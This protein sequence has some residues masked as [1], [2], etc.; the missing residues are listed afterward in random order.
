[1]LHGMSLATGDRSSAS[2]PAPRGRGR[3]R[4]PRS[5]QFF[6]QR[7][8]GLSRLVA[9]QMGPIAC[10]PTQPSRGGAGRVGRSSA[11]LWTAARPVTCAKR[12]TLQVR[13]AAHRPFAPAHSPDARSRSPSGDL[14]LILE[15]RDGLRGRPGPARS[16]FGF[17]QLA[18]FPTS[19][20]LVLSSS[21]ELKG[22]VFILQLVRPFRDMWPPWMIRDCGRRARDGAALRS[23][24]A[25]NDSRLK[26]CGQ[27]GQHTAFHI[28]LLAGVASLGKDSNGVES[29]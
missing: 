6:Q 25:S 27:R 29:A 16:R 5:E 13:R 26:I 10:R 22:L 28:G 8:D 18:L 15:R 4:S 2:E 21:P 19:R 9:I 24:P 20:A 23:R 3:C 17:P 7:Q 14:F 11:G 12:V 1:M